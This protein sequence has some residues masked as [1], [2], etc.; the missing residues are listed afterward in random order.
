MISE[1]AREL[2]QQISQAHFSEACETMGD[3]PW[4]FV[5]FQAQYDGNG[6]YHRTRQIV[7]ASEVN[8]SISM[9]SN[10]EVD[11]AL[12]SLE[13]HRIDDNGK[14]WVGVSITISHAG[15]AKIQLGYPETEVEDAKG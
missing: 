14:E 12:Q 8:E 9:T 1:S 10:N 11:A 15:E 5:E 13:E 7:T 6:G 2:I 3:R 4:E